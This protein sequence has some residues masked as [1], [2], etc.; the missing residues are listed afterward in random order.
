MRGWMSY[1]AQARTI[2]EQIH[3]YEQLDRHLISWKRVRSLSQQPCSFWQALI[4]TVTRVVEVNPIL[5]GALPAILLIKFSKRGQR[6]G[7]MLS[8]TI[9]VPRK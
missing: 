6:F 1:V 7:E 3:A 4:R 9:V 5:F 8:G 2:S